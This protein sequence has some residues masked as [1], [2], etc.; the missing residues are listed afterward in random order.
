MDKDR[1]LVQVKIEAQ[2]DLPLDSNSFNNFNNRHPQMQF[3][4][5]QLAA[6][7]NF[8]MSN[9]QGQ[10]SNQ[11]RQMSSMQI[12]QMQTQNMGIVRAPPVKVE[13]FQ[14]LMGGDSTPKLDSEENRLTSPSSK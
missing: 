2:S 10:S 14:E 13:G 4:Q 9:V 5:Q 3:R 6:M 11:F 8:A 7:S 12:P 1:P